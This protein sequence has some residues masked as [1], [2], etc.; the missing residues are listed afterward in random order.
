M[1]HNHLSSIIN[2]SSPLAYLKFSLEGFFR[3]GFRVLNG[4]RLVGLFE[5]FL[6]VFFIRQF[7]IQTFPYLKFSGHSE[8]Q[9][10]FTFDSNRSGGE[11]LPPDRDMYFPFRSP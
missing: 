10:I 2:S 4:V 11:E 9:E 8:F 3:K 1:Y 5:G 6:E 7:Q